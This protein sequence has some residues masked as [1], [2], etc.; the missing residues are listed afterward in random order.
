M[1]NRAPKINL[2]EIPDTSF[3]RKL[4]NASW[5]YFKRES[6]EPEAGAELY[7]WDDNKY[8]DA[9]EYNNMLPRSP[10]IRN[11]G[12]FIKAPIISPVPIKISDRSSKAKKNK[13][14]VLMHDWM[15]IFYREW[16]FKLQAPGTDK[17]WAQ[18]RLLALH[19]A[20]YFEPLNIQDAFYSL[21]NR[22]ERIIKN[23]TK[24]K[25]TSDF[26]ND[27]KASSC[28]LTQPHAHGSPPVEWEIE[29]LNKIKLLAKALAFAS[30]FFK[31]FNKF[32]REL[33]DRENKV[34][35]G[36]RKSKHQF[37]AE[38]LSPKLLGNKNEFE[39][40]RHER[41]KLA[42]I[43]KV[44]PADFIWTAE[45]ERPY[46]ELINICAKAANDEPITEI[47][48]DAVRVLRKWARG[49][50]SYKDPIVD[51]E[52]KRAVW[53]TLFATPTFHEF[54]PLHILTIVHYL[55]IDCVLSYQID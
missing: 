38:T 18:S 44:N 22:S 30:E 36:N 35:T 42:E 55:K 2:G 40:T 8:R 52:F 25:T 3:F 46:Y 20:N 51:L 12:K 33:A 47:T 28:D 4:P 11:H 45:H 17:V 13:A 27:M 49:Q 24:Y 32:G 14:C 15:S 26:N 19:S 5:T 39:I 43:S 21:T 31:Q 48:E 41:I 50:L 53:S 54:V 1:N 23:Y 29:I 10:L 37:T 34:G 9:S 7:S 16:F 6:D